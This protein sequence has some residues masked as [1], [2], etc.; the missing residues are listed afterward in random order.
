MRANT[1][2]SSL[3]TEMRVLLRQFRFESQV[4]PRQVYRVATQRNSSTLK[5][6]KTA[7][8]RWVSSRSLATARHLGMSLNWLTPSHLA[9]LPF[10]KVFESTPPIAKLTGPE[11]GY[12]SGFGAT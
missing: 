2:E 1:A 5:D 3:S 7:M 9:I 8:G 10:K 11:L 12:A 4:P 6:M